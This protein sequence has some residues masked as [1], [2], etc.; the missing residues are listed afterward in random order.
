MYLYTPNKTRTLLHLT[1]VPM[2]I[3]LHIFRSIYSQHTGTLVRL[4]TVPR[5]ICLHVYISTYLYIS[6][7]PYTPN[8]PAP[9]F[10]RLASS[11]YVYISTY[12][13][14]LYSSTYRHICIL[15]THWNPC[16]LDSR[17]YIFTYMCVY[18]STH[19]YR[20]TY[21]YTP[22]TPAPLFT[23]LACRHIC[24]YLHIY[25]DLHICIYLHIY[26]D[27]HVYILPTHR[28]PCSLD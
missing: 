27:L 14:T 17:V 6:T 25:T 7:Y 23:R 18:I 15:P 8:T 22:N 28:H 19:L 21:G 24:I 10:T 11:I 5:S 1:T 20:S 16:S 12:L 26:T 2:P 4:M 3:Y 9:L 13:Y